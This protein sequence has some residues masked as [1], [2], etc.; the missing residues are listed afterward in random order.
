MTD[1]GLR[2]FVEFWMELRTVLAALRRKKRGLGAPS[3]D[4]TWG[5]DPQALW[6]E[7]HRTV[8]SDG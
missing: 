2:R 3:R 1:P 7:R 4:E 8:V 6:I 5:I